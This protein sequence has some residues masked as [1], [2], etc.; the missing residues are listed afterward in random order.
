VRRRIGA[1]D[2]HP[3]A[4]RA[5]GKLLGD[6]RIAKAAW[7]ADHP[8]ILRK[9]VGKVRTE[10]PPGDKPNAP[11]PRADG[12]VG[13]QAPTIMFRAPAELTSLVLHTCRGMLN[14]PDHGIVET[15][16][17]HADLHAELRG[18]GFT[19]MHPLNQFGKCSDGHDPVAQFRPD[20]LQR[21]LPLFAGRQ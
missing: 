10:P 12:T 3:G 9:G 19:M 7:L 1:Q 2:D 14:V 11:M 15:A 20:R 8:E 13:A 6:L 5:L 16:A 17:D 4:A 21:V 18:R